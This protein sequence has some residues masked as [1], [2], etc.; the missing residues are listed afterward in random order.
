MSVNPVNDFKQVFKDAAFTK[1]FNSRYTILGK[2]SFSQV[3]RIS[4]ADGDDIAVQCIGVQ[5]NDELGCVLDQE[6]HCH[7]R[8]GS[9]SKRIVH[10]VNFDVIK[11]KNRWKKRRKIFLEKFL[12]FEW[13]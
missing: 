11:N 3:Y 13:R 10:F 4:C 12:Q 1:S 5:D 2:G 8:C 7:E 9:G 6:V